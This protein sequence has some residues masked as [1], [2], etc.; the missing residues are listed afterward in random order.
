LTALLDAHVRERDPGVV[1]VSPVDV[2]FDARAALVL[3]PDIVFVAR[4]RLG[5]VR[6]RIWGAPDLI[7]VAL[8]EV[9]PQETFEGEMV[10]RSTVLPAWGV[11]TAAVFP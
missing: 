5:I 4:E 2:V 8:A 7:V 3:Q 1:C 6:D 9:T 10:A 11:A